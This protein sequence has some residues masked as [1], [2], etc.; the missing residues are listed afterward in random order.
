M[1]GFQ[2]IGEA[3]SRRQV[4]GHYPQAPFG[5]G[6]LLHDV[7][8][9]QV[10]IPKG[11]AAEAQPHHR[12]AF[13][14]VVA[15]VDVQPREQLL[16]ALEQLLQRVQ[17]QALAEAPR[18]R[19]EV[20]CAFVEQALDVGRLVDVI[21]VLLPQRAE[22]LHADRQ[23]APSH[24]LILRK[25]ATDDQTRRLSA[26]RLGTP[27]AGAGA[28][29]ACARTPGSVAVACVVP[30]AEI[31]TSTRAKTNTPPRATQFDIRSGDIAIE[32]ALDWP[33]T[34]S[35]FNQAIQ[36]FKLNLCNKYN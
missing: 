14:P 35:T 3:A 34:H 7:G 11:A 29:F 9:Q 8:F 17:E 27:D 24:R 33:R 26:G 12:M 15:G 1:Q 6:E 32:T 31:G 5:G 28:V 20:V 19:Q 30:V 13:R 36:R 4:L 16:A 21:A 22:G 2:Q 23:S 18:P 25:V 10:R